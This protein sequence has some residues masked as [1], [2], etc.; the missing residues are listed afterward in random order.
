MFEI[1]I[2]PTGQRFKPGQRLRLVLASE[3]EGVAMQGLS[4]LSCGQA[5]K[6]RI[7][8]ESRLMVPIVG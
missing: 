5:A 6:N 2:V 3:D 4:H 1:A 8:A 7:F